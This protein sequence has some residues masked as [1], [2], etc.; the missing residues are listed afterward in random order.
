MT[1]ASYPSDKRMQYYWCPPGYINKSGGIT[2]DDWAKI[3]P[4][5]KKPV[6][7]G[8]AVDTYA[9]R[10]KQAL[11]GNELLPRKCQLC[12]DSFCGKEPETC[13]GPHINI[14]TN[15]LGDPV[16]IGCFCGK[17]PELQVN[18][19]EW[20][21]DTHFAYFCEC[22]RVGFMDDRKKG[23][24]KGWNKAIIAEIVAEAKK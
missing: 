16:L 8:P 10:V 13:D 1:I 18:H 6:E 3:F 14:P 23:A 15:E 21:R 9:E 17:M 22:G 2:A 4:N 5:G 20:T 7:D 12:D 11:G 19:D 24:I